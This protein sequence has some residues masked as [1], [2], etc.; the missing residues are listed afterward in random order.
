MSYP[1]EVMRRISGPD[2]KTFYLDYEDRLRKLYFQTKRHLDKGLPLQEA[3][4]Y[5]TLLAGCVAALFVLNELPSIIER[6]DKVSK[7]D[8]NG[9]NRLE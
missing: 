7:V 9:T 8:E 5:K 1:Y 3:H 4:D 6:F 2:G